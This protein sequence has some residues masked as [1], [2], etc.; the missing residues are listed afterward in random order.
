MGRYLPATLAGMS[1]GLPSCLRL[2]I[3]IVKSPSTTANTISPTVAVLDR[4]TTALSPGSKPTSIIDS[5]CIDTKKVAS[6]WSTRNS[7]GSR[8]FSTWSSAGD[9]KP[10]GTLELNRETLTGLVSTVGNSKSSIT[11]RFSLNKP[12]LM[13]RLLVRLLKAKFD[14]VE[15]DMQLL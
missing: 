2:S 9:G 5:P 11:S 10:A 1:L 13:L 15:V 7:V 6:A 12:E 3:L 4:S 8:R 14:V